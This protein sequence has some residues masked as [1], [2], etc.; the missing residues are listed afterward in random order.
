MSAFY[1]MCITGFFGLFLG[2]MHEEAKTFKDLAF[3][4]L[5]AIVWPICLILWVW[6]MYRISKEVTHG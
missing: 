6:R 3:L 2:L 4:Y 5:L 1:F